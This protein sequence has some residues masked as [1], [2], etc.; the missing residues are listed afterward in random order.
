MLNLTHID[1][2]PIYEMPYECPRS[3]GAGRTSGV[4]RLYRSMATGLPH[5]LAGILLTSDLQ[6]TE[7]SWQRRK[8]ESRLLGEAVAEELAVLCDL[9]GLPPRESIGV[10]LAGD[11]YVDVS[12]SK[13]GG[14]GDVRAIWQAFRDQFRWVAGVAGNHD[15]FGSTPQELEQ[16]KAEVG[17]HFLDGDHVKL[18]GLHVAGVGGIIG[19]PSKPF[20]REEQAFLGAIEEVMAVGPDMLV[21]HEGP[22]ADTPG[23]KGSTPVQE[24]L[25]RLDRTVVVCGHSHWDSNQPGVLSNETQVVNTDARAYLI[26]KDEGA[27]GATHR[28]G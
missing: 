12:L 15:Q 23:C 9:G 8:G 27:A 28:P 5:E 17:I 11:L 3:G 22:S 26:V 10:I 21:L 6:G 1:D 19:N 25:K 16:F 13:R 4:F 2:Q 7:P 20:R 14:K 18:D 24:L